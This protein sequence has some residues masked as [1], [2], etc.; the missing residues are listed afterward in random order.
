MTT[1]RR[2]VAIAG[3]AALA[4][5]LS[6]SA[7][8]EEGAATT[9]PPPTPADVSLTVDI[10]QS[11]QAITTSV[12]DRVAVTLIGNPSTRS[13][14]AVVEKPEFLSAPE[15]V[16]G[17]LKPSPSGRPLLGGDRWDVLVFTAQSA[18]EGTLKLE[19]R[20]GAGDVIGAFELTVTAK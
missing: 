5:A 9:L 18:G 14:W 7:W 17:P 2:H 6:A 15:R 8:A 20:S 3:F 11:G 12:G 10:E 13:M 16:S 1:S 4:L 19:R